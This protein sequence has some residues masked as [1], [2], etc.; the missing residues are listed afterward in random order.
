LW[1]NWNFLYKDALVD[2]NDMAEDV[3]KAGGGFEDYVVN[4]GKVNGRYIAIPHGNSNTALNYR[5]SYFKEAGLDIPDPAVQAKEGKWPDL[6]WEQL[7]ALG[8]K[9][10]AKGKPLGQAL[11]HSTG[12]PPGFAY[13]FMWSYGAMELDKDGK[14]VKF[15]APSFVDG[16]KLFIQAWKDAYDETGL[17]W[18]D[19]NNNRAFISDQISGTYNGSSIYTAAKKDAPKIAEDMNHMLYPKGPAGRFYLFET[20]TMGLFNKSKNID[21]AKE[22]LKWW[23]DDKRFGE[24][25]KIQDAYQLQHTKKWATDPMW[26]KDPKMSSFKEEPKY[27][28]N[29]G[30]AGGGNEKSVLAWSKYIIV[31]TF[32]KAVQSGDAAGSI[33]W[34]TD[35]LKK[36]YT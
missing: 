34:G 29:M 3:G 20:R 22:F 7:W 23:F 10:K 27:G 1:P 14:T 19:S 30:Y 31:D 9:L 33:K 6:T 35:E 12:D 24:W 13:S 25:L 8:K 17:S 16:M 5:I 36:I 4:S 32:A 15:D 11:G 28:R 18:D 26:D 2:L 21:G